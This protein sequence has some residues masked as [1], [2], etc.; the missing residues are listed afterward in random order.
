[1]AGFIIVFCAIPPPFFAFLFR[2]FVRNSLD[3]ATYFGPE[4]ILILA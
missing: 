2:F 1:M 3:W 4:S